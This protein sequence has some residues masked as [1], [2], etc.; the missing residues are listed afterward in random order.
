[1]TTTSKRPTVGLA[2]RGASSRS[3]FYV[4]FL[5]VL[6]EQGIP[7]DYIAAMSGGAIVA[8]SYACG[9]LNQLR[10]TALSLNKEL[11]SSLIERSATKSGVYHLDRV[12]ELLRVYTRNQKFED[13]QPHMG[14]I[15][16]D[17]N[18]G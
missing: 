15:A 8:A 12:E 11:I 6:H 9:T 7:I 3:V 14:F 13:V 16:V 18:K 4:G 5:E 17:I 10:E 2:L 1:M